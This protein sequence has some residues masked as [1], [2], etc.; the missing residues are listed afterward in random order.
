[1]NPIDWNIVR[2][3]Y[4]DCR[5]YKLTAE[6][7]GIKISTLNARA[8][9]EKWASDNAKCNADAMSDNAKCNADAMSDN[10]KCNVDA[11]SDNAT[12]NVDAMSTPSEG[13]PLIDLPGLPTLP[14]LASHAVSVGKPWEALVIPREKLPDKAAYRTYITSS[15]TRDCLF[16]GIRGVDQYQRVGRDNK[17]AAMLA[18]VTDYDTVLTEAA[19]KKCTDKL[20]IKPNFISTSYSGG[21]HAVWLL[22]APIPLMPNDKMVQALLE[23]IVRKLKLKNA[24]GPLDGNAFFNPAQYYHAGWDWQIVSTEPIAEAMTILWFDEAMKKSKFSQSG[25]QIP[26]PHIWEEMKRRGWD[27]RW[28]G[29]FALGARGC[30]FWDATADCPTAAIVRENGM[31]C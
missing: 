1:M 29:E 5:S 8:Y 10:A 4:L 9:R 16:S 22:Q 19:R 26:L 23:T 3:F 2:E 18:V 30:R 6:R 28:D 13:R 24:Y 25:V 20:V 17:P 31:E 27:S 11:M 7:F 14:N 15:N 21:T 12:C